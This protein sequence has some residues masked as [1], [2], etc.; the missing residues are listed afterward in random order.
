[1]N[2]T[3][4]ARRG[5]LEVLRDPDRVAALVDPTRR[6]LV[7][8]LSEGPDSAAGLARRLGESR[9]RLN[10]HLRALEDAGLV[11]LEEER[12][13]GNCVERVLR[14][15]ARR[16]VVDPA[17]LGS[18]A[19]GREATGDRFSATWLIALAARAIRELAALREK[20]AAQRRRLATAAIE[21]EVRLA[22]ATDF[23]PFVEELSRAVADVV[24]KH[25]DERGG[26]RPFRIVL[27]AYPAPAGTDPERGADVETRAR[28]EA[29]SETRTEQ[30]DPR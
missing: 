14:V 11:E 19:A 2:T 23:E 17:A 24:A 1:M 10:Y 8:A 12:R 28:S 21:S 22:R 3:S 13:R 20:A 29:H 25:H 7:E 15:V 6:R 16:F 4:T 26:G 5:G 27:G 18:L 9:Q 30:E